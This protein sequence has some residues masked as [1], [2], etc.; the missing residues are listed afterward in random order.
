ME[1]ITQRKKSYK[2]DKR[3]KQHMYTLCNFFRRR[4]CS[5][6]VRDKTITI[7]PVGL[8][9]KEADRL[10]RLRNYGF[11]VINPNQQFH[12]NIPVGDYEYNESYIDF[13][14]EIISLYGGSLNL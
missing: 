2:M 3:F 1:V 4:G 10:Q 13:A 7:D 9:R 6:N 14:D 8:Y 11:R 5:V 12:S